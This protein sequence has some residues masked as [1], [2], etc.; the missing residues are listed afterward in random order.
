SPT[1]IGFPTCF[2]DYHLQACICSR[3][4]LRGHMSLMRKQRYPI[5]SCRCRSPHLRTS[6]RIE[7][8]DTKS[9][10]LSAPR[11]V[12]RSL[13]CGYDECDERFHARF[14]TTTCPRHSTDRD[15]EHGRLV[16]EM[17]LRHPEFIR[18]CADSARAAIETPIPEDQLGRL[19]LIE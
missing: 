4:W 3:T 12:L 11:F 13:P 1:T 18:W 2:D 6:R 19:D 14:V 5:I 15:L 9:R 7:I 17:R 16:W 8:H 10:A